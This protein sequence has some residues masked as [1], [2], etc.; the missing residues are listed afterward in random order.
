MVKSKGWSLVTKKSDVSVSKQ[1][2][3]TECRYKMPSTFID[4]FDGDKHPAKAT[5]LANILSGQ[6]MDDRTVS[7]DS[8]VEIGS[9]KSEYERQWPKGFHDRLKKNIK[10]MSKASKFA[11]KVGDAHPGSEY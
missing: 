2:L 10:V 9:N 11:T 5:R 8:S 7:V 1:M 4:I 3:L 6:V